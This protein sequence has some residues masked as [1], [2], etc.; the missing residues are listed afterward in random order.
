MPFSIKPM[1]ELFN[2]DNAF[3]Q[4]VGK[5]GELIALTVITVFCCLPAVTAGASLSALC[6]ASFKLAENKSG[7]VFRDFFHSFRK[8]LAQGAV[9]SV[10][11]GGF[12]LALLFDVRFMLAAGNAGDTVMPS[13][14]FLAG[15]VICV[16]LGFFYLLLFLYVFPLQARFVNPVSVTLKNAVFAGLLY[17]PK[18]ILMAAADGA[19]AFL[20][21]LC[22][23]NWIQIAIIPA[24]LFPSLLC[25]FHAWVLRD[26]L[27]L[28]IKNEK[29]PKA[30]E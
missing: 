22:F 3:W 16:V 15:W 8:N 4:A 20:L 23:K 12:G 30:D 10:I 6:Y 9:L 17:L 14:F 21:L 26:L 29:L 1:G 24:L 27:G 11:F 7:G 25:C 2:T 13:A 5:A 18:T 28:E 19:A